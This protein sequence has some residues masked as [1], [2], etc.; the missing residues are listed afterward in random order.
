MLIDKS[1]RLVHN[2][3]VCS[4][5][6][7]EFYYNKNSI[8]SWYYKIIAIIVYIQIYHVLIGLNKYRVD[9]NAEKNNVTWKI[10]NGHFSSKELVTIK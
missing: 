9:H 7:C 4:L 6:F 10:I 3:F 5:L 2:L 8:S 1:L